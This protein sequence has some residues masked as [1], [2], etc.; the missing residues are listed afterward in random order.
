LWSVAKALQIPLDP[1]VKYITDIPYTISYT[2]RK[3]IQIDSLNELPKEKRPPDSI[4]WDGSSS[5][6]DSWI[7]RVMKSTSKDS[8]GKD[9]IIDIDTIEG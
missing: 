3:R 7:E 8:S 2:I 1:K 6:L 5:E 9:V 4:I